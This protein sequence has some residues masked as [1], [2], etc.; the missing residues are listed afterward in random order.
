LP[1]AEADR[2]Q[3]VAGYGV[4]V[5]M[6]SGRMVRVQIRGGGA[7]PGFLCFLIDAICYL[8]VPNFGYAAP[9]EV[10]GRGLPKL[11]R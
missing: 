2:W 8:P 4:T 6:S 11:E 9:R 3:E 1:T 7:I 10:A 5:T